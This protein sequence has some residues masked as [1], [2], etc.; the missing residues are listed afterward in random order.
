MSFALRT[1]AR[2][3]PFTKRTTQDGCLAFVILTE[4]FTAADG[5]MR[6]WNRI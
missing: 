4:S 1:A 5:G 3:T 2:M 6:E